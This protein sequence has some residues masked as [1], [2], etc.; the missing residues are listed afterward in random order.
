LGNDQYTKS[1]TDANSVLSNHK[2]DT[3]K[4]NY[5]NHQKHYQ[6]QTKQEQEPEKINLSFA[7][8]EGKCYCCGKP[9]HKS[10]Q[11]R[12]KDKPKSEWAINKN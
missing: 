10:P 12:F 6:D 11:C 8:M 4:Q 2:F 1:I 5:K 3:T 7:Q 9:G